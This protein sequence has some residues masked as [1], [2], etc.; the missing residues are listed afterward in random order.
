MGLSI[1]V[2]LLHDQ[3]RDD[4]EGYEHHL[5]AFDRLTRALRAEGVTWEEPGPPAPPTPH[6]FSGGFPYGDLTRLRRALVLAQAAPDEPV[7]PAPP[8]DDERWHHDLTRVEDETLM[9]ASHLLCHADN[10]GYYVPVDFP[11]PLF[12]PRE[13]G[14][15]GGGMV[16]STHRLLAEL[17]T[18]APALAIDPTIPTPPAPPTDEDP[19]SPERGAWHQLHR[20]CR[21]S[22]A[23]G[24][25]IVFH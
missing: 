6:T 3:A 17:T 5:A 23:G 11:D 8:T 2:G 10:A 21:E 9:F 7:P 12:L 22:L 19:L 4:R 24:H 16:G 13:A 25:A 1:S 15:A 14:V 18:L 20:A